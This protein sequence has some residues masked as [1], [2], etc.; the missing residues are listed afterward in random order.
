M[1]HNLHNKLAE[2]KRMDRMYRA[3]LLHRCRGFT[4]GSLSI[5]DGDG[6]HLVGDIDAPQRAVLWVRHRDFYRRVVTGGTL[7]A[8]ESWM[9][10]EWDCSDLVLLIRLFVR[11]LEL[12]DR[13]QRS[14]HPL[15][16][17]GERLRHWWR[18]NSQRQ[19]RRNIQAHYDLS[20]DF[21]ALFLDP[22]LNYSSAL[23]LSDAARDLAHP[24]AA[25]AAAQ[26]DKMDA[27]CRLLQLR[28]GDRL[29]EIGT[30]WGALACHAARHY[31]CR[32]VTT[33]ISRAQFEAAQQRVQR[34][35]LTDRV[36]VLDRDYRDLDGQFDKIVSVEMIEAVGDAYYPDFFRQCGRL[37]KPDGLLLLQAITIVDARYETHL[38]T[39]DFICK[40]IFPG[41]SL[42]CLSRLTSVASSAAGLRLVHYREFS[43]HY[44]R[45]LQIWRQRFQEQLDAVRQ[46]GFDARFVRMWDYYLAYCEAGFAERQI[47]VG[48]LLFS[49]HGS[50][51][52]VIA[53]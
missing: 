26:Q 39:V 19:A 50:T 7:A 38:R 4:H 11:N 52:E 2:L 46:L 35:E 30:G 1:I 25:L 21:F 41:G 34:L 14:V 20:N 17:L 32:V 43:Q 5:V 10:G 45:T 9:D 33:T 40:Y 22:S 29:L 42:P 3:L 16:R 24:A 36:T 37:L 23:F 6:L 13:W 44:V 48:H 27:I 28:P 47:N 15:R 49:P 8:S 12:A 53:G 31:G 51:A 18:G